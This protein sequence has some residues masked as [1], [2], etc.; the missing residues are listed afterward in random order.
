MSS[1]SGG[2]WPGEAPAN[3]DSW[4]DDLKVTAQE[5]EPVSEPEPVVEV[6]PQA[7][8]EPDAE[9]EPELQAEPVPEPD[10][11]T[12][13]WELPESEPEPEPVIAHRPGE[14]NVPGG[15]AVID[16]A[17]FGS[18][19]SVGIVVARFNSE[20]SKGLLES[21]LEALAAAGVE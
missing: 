2:F 18:G 7:E 17:P 1:S 10:S 14:I 12:T 13:G 15:I 19:R 6:E 5:P 8:P 11:E 4:E 3:D 9:P 16:G 20:I 21:A